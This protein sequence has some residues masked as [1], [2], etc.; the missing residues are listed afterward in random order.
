M[1]FNNLKIYFKKIFPFIHKSGKDKVTSINPVTLSFND[2]ELNREFSEELSKNSVKVVRFSM[3]FGITTYLVFAL[4]EDQ[5]II[6]NYSSYRTVGIIQFITIIILTFTSLYKKYSQIIIS[7]LILA[8]GFNVLMISLDSSNTLYVGLILTSIYAHSLLRFRFLFASLTTWALIIAYLI[9]LSFSPS[10]PSNIIINNTFFLVT[11]NLL[12]MVASYSIEF[13][14]KTNFWQAKKLKEKTAIVKKEFDR[15]SK[16]LEDAREIQL[17]ML[18]KSLPLHP[19]VDLSVS[20]KTASEIGGDYYDYHLGDDFTLTFAVGDAT[21]HG[22]Q[23]GVMVTALKILFTN[24]A[25]QMDLVGF[26]KK[27]D[28][29]IKQIGL[30]RLYMSLAIGR[31]RENTLEITGVGMP[32]LLIYRN[33]TKR[34]ERIN[35]KGLPLG[36]IFNFHYTKHTI[37]LLPGDTILLMT[38]GFPESFNIDKEMFGYDRIE[39]V[40]KDESKNHPK[41]IISR[42]NNIISEWT[43]SDGQNDDITMMVIKMKDINSINFNMDISDKLKAN[44]FS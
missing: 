23:A 41:K 34:I 2:K 24:Y 22:A 5:I 16:E 42:F 21:G 38:D 44:F 40:F 13:Y 33:N 31:L 37:K 8:G 6:N 15:K 36:S 30:P 35:L 26:M 9:I 11:A 3:L 1:M 29:A 20:M 43:K 4:L 32:P 18:P 14:M 17:S 27:A 39:K 10:I 28:Q 12:G 25:H 7:G 19:L